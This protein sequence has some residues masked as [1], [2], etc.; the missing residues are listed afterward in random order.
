MKLKEFLD[1][2][3]EEVRT[4]PYILELDVI[5]SGDDE[6]NSFNTV[7]Y[8]PSVGLYKDREFTSYDENEMDVSDINVICIN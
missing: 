5:T 6:G 2:I 3:N 8:E 1:N 7:Y 4:N